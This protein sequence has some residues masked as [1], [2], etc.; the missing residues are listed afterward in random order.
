M[1][2]LVIRFSS[3]GDCFL[4]T[5]IFRILKENFPQS[6][7]H[8][9]TKSLYA[10]LFS[11]NPHIDHLHLLT[12]SFQNLVSS[13]KDIHFDLVLDCHNVLRSRRL[14]S[15]LKY[16]RL[17][18]LPKYYFEKF[19]IIDLKE[20]LSLP[21]LLESYRCL[22]NQVI[23]NPISSLSPELYHSEESELKIQKLLSLFP[24]K[25]FFVFHP[26]TRGPAKQW[27]WDHWKKLI[28]L[29]EEHFPSFQ[30]F[31]TGGLEEEPLLQKLTKD[32][33]RSF[34][35][36]GLCDFNE[37]GLI[38]QK[39]QAVV[40][41]DTAILHLAQYYQKPLVLI[42]GAT[43][44]QLGYIQKSYAHQIVFEHELPCR[45]CSKNGSS[46][47]PYGSYDCLTLTKPE[48]VFEAIKKISGETSRVVPSSL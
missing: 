8:F 3:L 17:L 22:V 28:Q 13:L 1:K 12:D 4:L 25:P 30:I 19:R 43:T 31:L 39:A 21:H 24:D 32:S 23:A 16:Q 41:G 7:I 46:P 36:A 5:G 18:R 15:R 47:C 6:D 27:P 29:T 10:S 14:T 2:I 34:S 38:I 44:E 11:Q 45:P 40:C 42:L 20:P 9:V 37:L 26:C 35:L 33:L 48:F